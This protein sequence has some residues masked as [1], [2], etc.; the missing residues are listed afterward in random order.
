MLFSRTMAVGSGEL[1]R[2]FTGLVFIPVGC[3]AT[4]L[5]SKGAGGGADLDTDHPS[6]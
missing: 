5:T 1:I 3:R 4:L 6:M 2:L